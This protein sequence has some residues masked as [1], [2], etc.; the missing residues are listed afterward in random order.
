MRIGDRGLEARRGSASAS[1]SSST[2]VKTS[3]N[4]SITSTSSVP[5]AGT[6]RSTARRSPCSSR[7]SCSIRLA[8]GHRRDPEQRRLELLERVGAR[9]HVDDEPRAPSPRARR[10]AARDAGRPAP[11][12]TCRCRSARPPPGTASSPSRSTSC[13]DQRLAS[14]EVG[15]V[16]LLERPQALVGVR[17]V[18]PRWARASGRRRPQRAPERRV[19]RGVVRLGPEPDDLYGLGE[20]LQSDRPAVDEGDALDLPGQVHDLA[21]RQDL[22]RSRRSSTGAPR[23][24]AR[25]R[26]TRRR[27]ATAS[28]ASSPIPTGSGRVG[29]ATVSSTNRRWSSTAARIACRAESKTARAS[30]PRSS[31]SVALA[32]LEHLARDLREPGGEPAAASSPCSCVKTV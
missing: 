14:E 18:A 2:S 12:R 9:E 5:S 31:T 4:W 32:R 3:S 23:G 25:R 11:P 24:S 29:S 26:G 20:P 30:S 13:L 7:S 17:D 8:G 28:P 10:R 16:G 21:A 22:G 1:S 19:V 6:S 27:P 15:R